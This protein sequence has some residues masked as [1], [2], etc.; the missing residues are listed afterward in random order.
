MTSDTRSSKYFEKKKVWACL[1]LFLPIVDISNGSEWSSCADSLDELTRAA[2][3]ASDKAAALA[4]IAEEV[5][6]KKRDLQNCRTFP[7]MYDFLDDGCT[8]RVS[9]YNREVSQYNS[10]LGW[11]N[12]ELDTVSRK[13][14]YAADACGVGI[15]KMDILNPAAKRQQRRSEPLCEA[16]R[17]SKG[18]LPDS[19]LLGICKNY[20]PEADCLQCI[21]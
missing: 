2:R 20:M 16:V 21:N 18:R 6:Q 13:S 14:R 9:A 10:Q 19:E 15:A 17:M 12:S 1:L 4:R 3:D 8:G 7:E 11:L 5:E